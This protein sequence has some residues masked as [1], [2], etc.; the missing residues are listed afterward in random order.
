[1]S[2]TPPATRAIAHEAGGDWTAG[3]RANT[4]SD[5]KRGQAHPPQSPEGRGGRCACPPKRPEGPRAGAY[6]KERPSTPSAEAREAAATGWNQMRT[7]TS[8][9]AP[10]KHTA[11]G[12]GAKRQPGPVPAAAPHTSMPR[13]TGGVSHGP[14]ARSRRTAHK[15]ARSQRPSA[16]R[17]GARLSPAPNSPWPN[18]PKRCTDPARS[19][20]SHP[21]P[22]LR[23]GS[24]APGEGVGRTGRVRHGRRTNA[25]RAEGEQRKGREE[26]QPTL[27][28]RRGVP[29]LNKGPA[30]GSCRGKVQ[31]RAGGQRG[32]RP[33]RT[34]K[35][36]ARPGRDG[37]HR[38]CR[39]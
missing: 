13:D 23:T 33:R 1:M 16:R 22:L 26:T 34:T 36:I 14:R 20:R 25:E 27:P 32:T 31:R 24:Q 11:P 39:S 2:Q 12:V 8:G 28:T 19:G 5:A 17:S 38:R 30:A 10:P 29:G 37:W 3:R 35:A 18:V 15:R 6:P 4:T 7:H 21:S 9:A